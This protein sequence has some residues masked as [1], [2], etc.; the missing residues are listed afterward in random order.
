MDVF[1]AMWMESNNVYGDHVIRQTTANHE[2]KDGSVQI[3][4]DRKKMVLMRTMQKKP[5]VKPGLLVF[6]ERTV[7]EMRIFSNHP[8]WRM[9][10]KVCLQIKHEVRRLLVV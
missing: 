5:K 8:V 10:R 1:G 4:E 3:S 7:L 9:G 2:D 6:S